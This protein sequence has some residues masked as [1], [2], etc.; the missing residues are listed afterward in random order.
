MSPKILGLRNSMREFP[1]GPTSQRGR[2]RSLVVWAKSNKTTRVVD[3]V[4][5]L[6]NLGEV[7]PVRGR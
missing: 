4:R 7:M 1:R 6:P 2:Q 3:G 5:V